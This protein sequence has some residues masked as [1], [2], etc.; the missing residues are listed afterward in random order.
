MTNKNLAFC[1]GAI[2]DGVAQPFVAGTGTIN[3]HVCQSIRVSI[4][5]P[6][7]YHSALHSESDSTNEFGLHIFPKSVLRHWKRTRR[8]N[9][10]PLYLSPRHQH[11]G[12][13]APHRAFPRT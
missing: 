6:R 2:I 10:S 8:E 1:P 13:H 11:P 12:P 3:S 7:V 5:N 9:G 4:A